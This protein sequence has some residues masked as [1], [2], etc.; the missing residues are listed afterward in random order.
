MTPQQI[1]EY[2]MKWS[3]GYSVRLHSD[4][5]NQGK[6]WCKENCQKQEW[7]CTSWTSQYEYTFYF[8]KVE[9]A[10]KFAKEMGKY[11]NQ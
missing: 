2:R 3:P 11:S 10:E 9:I 8:E 6:D 7:S 4:V 5:A 1:F